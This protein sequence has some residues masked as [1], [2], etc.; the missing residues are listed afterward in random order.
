MRRGTRS[1]RGRRKAASRRGRG[2]TQVALPRSFGHD[3]EDAALDEERIVVQVMFDPAHLDD[4]EVASHRGAHANVD[5]AHAEVDDR[6]RKELLDAEVSERGRVSAHLGDEERRRVQVAQLL[7]ELEDLVPWALE[8]RQGVQRV[9]A[10]EGD[11]VAAHLLLVSREL[12]AQAEEPTG[13][14]ADLLDLATQR[15]NVDDVDAFRVPRI[16]PEG[17]HLRDERGAA[18]LHRKIEARGAVFLRLVE[19]DAVDERRFQ[20]TGRS[21]HQDDVTA[22]DSAAQT[23]VQA[24]DVGGNLVGGLGQRGTPSPTPEWPADK[25]GGE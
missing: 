24:D 25:A 3:L 21:G 22:R 19:E 15:A 20:G 1:R 5:L 9:E 16:H 8:R 14:F 6:V 13:L 23:V 12:A 17:G 18:L 4:A 2:R 10:V 7:E 11:Q